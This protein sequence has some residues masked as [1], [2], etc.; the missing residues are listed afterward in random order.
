MM[1]S[2][3]HV[4]SSCDHKWKMVLLIALKDIFAICLL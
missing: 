3:F 1:G 4:V 2:G